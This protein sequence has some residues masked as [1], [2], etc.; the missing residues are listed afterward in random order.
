MNDATKLFYGT[1][2]KI[3]MRAFFT[4]LVQIYFTTLYNTVITSDHLGINTL[5]LY[6]RKRA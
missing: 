3:S 5:K 1:V 4:D 2:P 6:C